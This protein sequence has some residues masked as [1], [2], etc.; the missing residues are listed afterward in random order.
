MEGIDHIHIIQIGGRRFIGDVCRMIERKVPDREGLEFCIARA[1]AALV[2]MVDVGQAG[3]HFS[4]AGTR[5]CDNDKGA[6]GFNIFVFPVALVT[7]NGGNVVRVAGDGVV[8]VDTQA[9]VAQ[10][11]FEGDKPRMLGITGQHNA[12]HKQP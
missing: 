10:L 3:C 1:D 11:I 5:R 7:D 6:R 12:A 4:A 8:A 2:I 9:K